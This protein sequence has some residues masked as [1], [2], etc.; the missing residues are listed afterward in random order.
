LN[1]VRI[2]GSKYVTRVIQGRLDISNDS[3]P[4]STHT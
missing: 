3:Y 2:H 4:P 1:Y